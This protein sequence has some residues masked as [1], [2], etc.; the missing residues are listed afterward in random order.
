MK[1]YTP[2][3]SKGR[4]VGGDDIYHRTAD[5]PKGGAKTVAKVA[6]HSARQDGKKTVRAG[7]V[8]G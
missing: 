3:T 1:P 2:Q 4:T 8:E 7:V 5:M 6:K